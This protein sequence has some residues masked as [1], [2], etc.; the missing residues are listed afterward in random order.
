MTSHRVAS[1]SLIVEQE[2]E[3]EELINR[4]L[5]NGQAKC[6]KQASEQDNGKPGERKKDEI[7]K[8]GACECEI[9]ANEDDE[10]DA[11]K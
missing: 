9:T 7:S 11:Q 6:V 2:R 4:Y 10:R 5:I 3:E 8:N 1:D